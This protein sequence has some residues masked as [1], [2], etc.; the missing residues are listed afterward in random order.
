MLEHVLGLEPLA[1]EQLPP[2]KVGHAEK[3][4][5]NLTAAAQYREREGSLNVG[6]KHRE[7]LALPDGSTVEV[8]LGLFI[9]NSR[10]RHADIPTARAAR[11][12]ELG[13]RWE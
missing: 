13:M 3:E 5:R 1:A 10:S 7:L 2:A 6:R 8:S 4:R 9:A 12:T 11:L